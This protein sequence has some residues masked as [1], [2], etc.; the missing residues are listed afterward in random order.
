MPETAQSGESALGGESPRAGD[1]VAAPDALTTMAGLG[2]QESVGPAGADSLQLG[3]TLPVD[4]GEQRESEP[5]DGDFADGLAPAVSGMIGPDIPGYDIL[6]ELGRGGMGV[7]YLAR[8]SQLNRLCA[9]KMILAGDHAGRESAIR[10][11]T[12]AATV[13]RLRHPNI[14]Q[15]Y[16]LGE[17]DHRPYLE[18]EYVEGGS[19]AHRLDGTPWTPRPAA[20]LV[21]LLARAIDEAHQQAII[22]RDLKPANVLLA[23]DG[24]PKITDFGLAKSLG[25]DSSLT[26]SGAIMGSPSYMAPE[27]AGGGAKTVGRSADIYALGAILYELLTGRPPFRAATV[28]ETLDQV[29]NV[30]PVAPSRLVPGLPRDIETIALKCLQK[31]PARRY[32]TAA[33]LAEDLRR[34]Q[35][36]Q[37]IV[38]RPVG[39]LERAGRWCLRNK[40]LAAAIGTAAAALLIVAVMALLHAERQHHFATEQA[41]ATREIAGLADRLNAS[42][43]ESNRRLAIRNFERGQ[44]FLDKDQTGPGLLWMLESWQSAIDARDPAWQRAARANV[45]AWLPRL[46]RIK[47]VF[48]HDAPVVGTASSP[49]GKLVVTGSEDHTAQALGRVDR[50][51]SWIAHAAPRPGHWRRVQ[52]GRKARRDGEQ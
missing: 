2:P 7:V 6:G 31:D 20:R 13:A 48:S 30:E 5:P 50:P 34:F 12:E 51:A 49:D 39:S 41:R 52:P 3:T 45:S 36:G 37:T 32:E 28:L 23:V 38:A 26:Q 40:A 18:L 47:A 1:V 46:P 42:L 21:E 4:P 22:H 8:Q 33:V 44:T 15:I 27:Q 9:L 19:L 43:V 16:H 24:T 29:K 17:Q 25:V 11:L 35:D 10:F 14:V